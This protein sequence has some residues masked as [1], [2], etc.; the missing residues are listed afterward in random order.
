MSEPSSTEARDLAY[1]RAAVSDLYEKSWVSGPT[2]EL[3]EK[4]RW[5]TQWWEKADLEE[6]SHRLVGL[7]SAE[8]SLEVSRATLELL[9][10][11]TGLTREAAREAPR[12]G[13]DDEAVA[14]LGYFLASFEIPSAPADPLR[15]LVDWLM[16]DQREFNT[17]WLTSNEQSFLARR[18]QSQPDMATRSETRPEDRHTGLDGAA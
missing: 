13:G 4:A 18:R 5:L 14:R 11:R 10:R 6:L 9:L 1:L 3:R 7:P 8:T 16:E 15:P 2:E 12:R 17:P